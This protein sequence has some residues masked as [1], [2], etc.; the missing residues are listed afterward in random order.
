MLTPERFAQGYDFAAYTEK[1]GDDGHKFVARYEKCTIRPDDAAF[2]AGS[3]EPV[4]IL[5]LSESWCPD[6]VQNVPIVAKIASLNPRLRVSIF[7]RDENLD[8]M[9][10]FL[11][12]GRRTIPTVVF[13]DGD[14]KEIGRW[15]ERPAAV[16]RGL[17]AGTD[18]AKAAVKRD[19]LQGKYQDDV[20]REIREILAR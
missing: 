5:V 18:E 4:N 7:P 14:F 13:F 20:V 3:K 16:K 6:C 17:A 1:M 15:I 19:Y 12:D 2:F 10:E 8:V 9:D 11:T